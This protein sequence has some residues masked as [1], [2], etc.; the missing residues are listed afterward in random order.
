[1]THLEDFEDTCSPDESGSPNDVEV[2]KHSECGR[3]TTITGPGDD[4]PND[5]GGGVIIDGP[6]DGDPPD[7]PRPP[8]VIIDDPCPCVVVDFAIGPIYRE[9]GICYRVINVF[10]ECKPVGTPDDPGYASTLATFHNDGWSFGDNPIGFGDTCDCATGGPCTNY[11]II[12]SKPCPDDIGDGDPIGGGGGGAAPGAPARKCKCVVTELQPGTQYKT[13]TRCYFPLMIIKECREEPVDSIDYS[14]EL[15]GFAFQG[16]QIPTTSPNTENDCDCA[17]GGC[18]NKIIT[19]WKYCPDDVG[20]GDPVG[21]GGGAAPGA[22]DPSLINDP[23]LCSYFYCLDGQLLQ[24]GPKNAEYWNQQNSA[25]PPVITSCSELLPSFTANDGTEYSKTVIPC[26]GG[27]GAAPGAPAPSIVPDGI[28]DLDDVVIDVGG[29]GNGDTSFA[30]GTIFDTEGGGGGDTTIDG[31]LNGDVFDT[32]GGGGGTIG[33]DSTSMDVNPFDSVATS[34]GSNNITSPDTPADLLV[35]SLSNR[36]ASGYDLENNI[37]FTNNIDGLRYMRASGNNPIYSE[38]N[39]FKKKIFNTLS[40]LLRST[41]TDGLV[42]YNGDEISAFVYDDAVIT[43]NLKPLVKK[44]IDD[45]A[46]K[47]TSSYNFPVYMVTALKNAIIRGRVQDYTLTFLNEIEANHSITNPRIRGDSRLVAMAFIENYRK[48]LFPKNYSAGESQRR[49][50]MYHSLPTDI[51]LKVNVLNQ[52]GEYVCVCIDDTDDI[53]IP[54]RDGSTKLAASL[55]EFLSVTSRDGVDNTLKLSSKRKNAYAFDLPKLST[56]H[57]LLAGNSRGL[58]DYSFKLATESPFDE[59][60][61][62]SSSGNL[63]KEAYL[64]KI[65][66]RSIKSLPNTTQ[67]FRQT[68]CTYST[69]WEEGDSTESFTAGVEDYYGPRQIVYIDALDP[70]WNHFLY[71]KKISATYTD[72][73]IDGVFNGV[74]PRVINMDMLL[75]P[76]T[77]VRY[78]PYQGNSSLD[79]YTTGEPVVRSVKVVTSPVAQSLNEVY[80]QIQF[81]SDREARQGGVDNFAVHSTKAYEDGYF[82]KR[83]TDNLHVRTGRS[84]VGRFINTITRVKD[85]Y[86]LGGRGP[87]LSLPQRDLYSF[88]KPKEVCEFLLRIP[89]ATRSAI[90]NGDFTGVKVFAVESGDILKTY[91]TPDREKVKGVNL[92]SLR[93]FK[94]VAQVSSKYFDRDKGR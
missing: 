32:G 85:T 87:G 59:E 77:S 16:W 75:V 52:H 63:L 31:I 29:G 20:D 46:Y 8:P 9:E 69:I 17:T 65:D 36:R 49:V 47:N 64:I 21:G 66:R 33:G 44:Y 91:L 12:M 26:G 83:A 48:S 37:L 50:Q 60:I 53:I 45:L 7:P 94:Q 72:L 35:G 1:M 28:G 86:S 14:A 56:L 40:T 73:K 81:D 82:R 39:L 79:N 43:D 70:F 78:N 92:D 30:D 18:P 38:N 68:S 61:E 27:G 23:V 34:F 57:S 10:R 93:I 42:P 24:S 84:V 54:A 89:N 41:L 90:I 2:R 76:T 51:N 71:S 74:Y 88:M 62:V 67:D 5:I 15:Q 25:N 11:S 80:A 58:I 4:P 6:G 3:S 22:P 19:L 13:G 55:N